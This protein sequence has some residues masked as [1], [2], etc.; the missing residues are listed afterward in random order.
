MSEKKDS[1]D[2]SSLEGDYEILGEFGG[3]A[4]SRAFTARR[5]DAAGKR[6]DDAN[7]VLITVV[8]PPEGDEGN[9]LNHLAADTK[10]LSRLSHRRMVPVIEGRW[11]GNDAFAL[12]TQRLNDETLAQKL[13]TR[14]PFSNPRI[15]AILREVNGLLEWAREQN[16]VHREVSANRI[17][18]EPMTDRVRVS[19]GISSIP[20]IQNVDAATADARTIVRLAM[21]M[22]LGQ[23]DP[24]LYET[25]CLADLRSD[26]PVRLCEA[27]TSLLDPK[28]SHTPD[29]VHSFISLIGMADP[30]F[31]GEEEANRLRADV[32]EEARVLRETIANERA[33]HERKMAEERAAFEKMMTEQR[34]A[35]ELLMKTEREKAEKLEADR[36]RAA[37]KEEADRQR[38][39][40]AERERLANEKAELQRAVMAERA[41][42]VAKT[43]EMERAIAERR[44]EV[45]RVA[46]EDRARLE[47]L[48]A[49]L[50]YA[51]E[52]ELEARRQRELDEMPADASAL[53]QTDLR[54]LPFVPPVI[55]PL[56]KLVFDNDSVLMREDVAEEDDEEAEDAADESREMEANALEEE[57][58]P[59]ETRESPSELAGAAATADKKPRKK[60]Y[61]PGAFV[62]LLAIGGISAMALRDRATPAP[63]PVT[64]RAPAP[65][66][67]Q[68]VATP[69]VA[70]AVPL[71]TVIV[72]SSAGM[73]S[74]LF[75]ANGEVRKPVARKTKPVVRD[76]V[77]RDAFARD[78]VREADLPPV[79]G[80]L[81]R[82][83]TDTAVRRDTAPKRDS[84]AKPDTTGRPADPR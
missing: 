2:L 60:W 65:A 64:T 79:P 55:V 66:T 53:E 23:D 20:R 45:E 51:G 32:H 37:A 26:L 11:L 12:V 19:F 58:L 10:M 83:R 44:A 27:S 52:A 22:L 1:L 72:D 73:M 80:F 24:T 56:E 76:T 30:L 18:L 84:V 71:P 8:R 28:K 54:A 69:S 21:A 6:R 46:A 47:K 48:R 42:L 43:E 74:P 7:G 68:P 31:V 70:P 78:S 82:P 3:Q 59:P 9:A 35:F 4:D 41:A 5:K 62:A 29:E 38:A 61:I 77:A 33:E 50:L 81:P 63:A 39:A 36:Q 75:D 67:A 25:Q 14:E 13:V 16:V 57:G 17:Y 40:A 49:E 15:A 34:E